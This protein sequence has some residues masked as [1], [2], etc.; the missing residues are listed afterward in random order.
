VSN[1]E[2]RDLY[3]FGCSGIAK[4]L[5]DSILRLNTYST[6]NITLV[7][8]N[9]ALSGSQFYQD[10][11]VISDSEFSSK[12]E[13]KGDYI[14]AFYKP[15]DI[16]RRSEFARDIESTFGLNPVTVIDKRAYV[17]PTAS[18]GKG[19]YVAPGVV[20]DAEASI[21]DHSIVLFNSIIS[22]ECVL[23]ENNFI[24]ASVVVKGSVKINANNFISSNCVVT[25]KMGSYNFINSG[26]VLNR[27]DCE[28]MLLGLKATFVEIAFPELDAAA[29]KKLRY[30][31]P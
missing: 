30:L 18:I 5:I 27:T 25:Q 12:A 14:C 19:V 8:K 17:S 16:F 23:K 21:G 4:S 9:E 1:I 7:D 28:R 10:I 11:S 22:R 20:V 29:E 15:Y 2:E 3:I 13:R 24:S 31:N 6:K 26:I